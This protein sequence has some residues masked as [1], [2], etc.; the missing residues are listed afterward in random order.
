MK[1]TLLIAAI[2]PAMLTATAYADGFYGSVKMQHALQ[3]LSGSSLTTPGAD[4]R[5]ANPKPNNDMSG[6]LAL[7][8]AFDGGW[9]LEGEYT[10]KT[11]S[12]FNT[13]WSPL[14]NS[15]NNMQ[16]NT[17]R[18]MFNGYKDFAVTDTISVYGMAGIGMG[19]VKSVGYQTNPEGDFSHNSQNNLAYSL[20]VGADFKVT[21]KITLGTGYRYVNMG[22]IQTGRN[23]LA[24]NVN[25][26]KETMKGKL[27]EQNLF[28]EA[29]VGF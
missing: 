18:F 2:L 27:M 21:E 26:D 3:S 6:S 22:N 8:Y 4:H 14:E 25:G 9:R 5:T 10:G 23:L 7:G 1:K 24:N 29:R 13:Q 20:G 28:V 15:V 12:Q 16:T 17:Q 19:N 11:E